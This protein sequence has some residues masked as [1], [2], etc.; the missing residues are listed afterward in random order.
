MKHPYLFFIVLLF[1]AVSV[2]QTSTTAVKKSDAPI[3]K[4]AVQQDPSSPLPSV[5][6]SVNGLDPRRV[7]DI[8]KK[9]K[10]LETGIDRLID[11]R[12]NASSDE[13]NI[14]NEIQ[15]NITAVAP[16]YPATIAQQDLY[17]DLVYLWIDAY[18]NE[19]KAAI[20]YLTSENSR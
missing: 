14:S 3:S 4:I 12:K 8:S 20:E 15:S 16:H 6:T 2:A 18:P 7:E 19:Y 10:V 11:T 1:S 9:I 17:N 5:K 13:V